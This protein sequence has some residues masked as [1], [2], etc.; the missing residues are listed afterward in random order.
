MADAT[1]ISDLAET[2]K[3]AVSAAG[4]AILSALLPPMCPLTGERVDRPGALSAAAWA[5][6]SFIDDPVC[7]GCGVPFA[8]DQGRGAVCAACAAEPPAVDGARAA[9]LYD[10]AAHDLIVAFKHADRTDLAPLLAAW[11]ARAGVPFLTDRAVLAPVP[12]HRSRLFRR[13]YNQSALLAQRLAK[14][15]RLP[16]VPNGLVRVRP[17]PS[18]Q[19]LSAV[20]RRRNLAGAIA[21]GPGSAAL[22]GRDVVL[23]DDV[24]T[25]GSTLS[26]AA[27]AAR[28]AGAAKVFGLVLARAARGVIEGENG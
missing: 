20:A 26:A 28:R 10:D 8:Y 11:L 27:R 2:A 18:Q 22:S 25:T 23:V 1:R 9:I 21:P 5:R 14:T 13:R 4:S 24:L 15:A 6:V 16:Y 19:G 7:A 17:T 12:L 3:T